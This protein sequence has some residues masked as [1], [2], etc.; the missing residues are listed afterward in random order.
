MRDWKMDISR[1]GKPQMSRLATIVLLTLM[2]ALGWEC[3]LLEGGDEVLAGNVIKNQVTAQKKDTDK[4]SGTDKPAEDEGP[5]TIEKL[6][7]N[8]AKRMDGYSFNPE[9]RVDPFRPIDAVLEASAKPK[10]TEDEVPLPPLQR[11]ELSQLKLVAVIQAGDRTRALVEDSTGIGFIIKVG[12]LMGT[13]GGQVTSIKT[14]K[15]EVA[16]DY[17]DY[18]GKTKVRISELKLRPKEGEDQ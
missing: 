4:K 1:T 12:T 18:L 14:D 7:A 2:L 5:L 6:E 13:R 11:M 3:G 17:K 15:I 16:E 9:G 8:L 10:T